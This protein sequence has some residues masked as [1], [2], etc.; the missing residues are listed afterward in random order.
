MSGFKT[1]FGALREVIEASKAGPAGG[2]NSPGGYL[3]NYISW[4]AGERKIVRFLDDDPIIAE[5]YDWIL[6]ND[7]KTKNFLIDPAKGDLVAKYA[8]ASPGLGWRRDFLSGNLDERKVSRKGIGLAVLRDE[9]P[10]GKGG[11]EVVDHFYDLELPNSPGKKFRAR[12]FGIIIQ[13]LNNFWDQVDG[14]E[15]R[16]GS[17][18]DRDYLIERRGA[19]LDTRYQ[20]IPLDPVE[21]LRDVESVQKFYGYGKP[22]PKRPQDDASAKDREEWEDRF[23]YCPQTLQQWAE[24]FSSEDRVKHWLTP[25][26]GS[27]DTF[28]SPPAAAGTKAPSWGSTTDEAQV[29]VSGDTDFSSLKKRLLENRD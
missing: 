23:L 18:T 10:S 19:G 15:R 5:F 3:S 25:V 21:E 28:S 8:S 17:I 12:Y 11:T 4:K 26:G 22:W 16:Y 1:G 7:G 6:T 24:D 27:A 9:A 14:F 13:G 20:I 29:A 2:G